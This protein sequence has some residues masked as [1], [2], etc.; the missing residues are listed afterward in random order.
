MG[1][2]FFIGRY[3]EEKDGLMVGV[4]DIDDFKKNSQLSVT[5]QNVSTIL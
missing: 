4:K 1:F 2:R 5:F 3:T